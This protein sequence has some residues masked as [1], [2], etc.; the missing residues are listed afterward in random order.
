MSLPSRKPD[1]S[2][3]NTTHTLQILV[4]IITH[5]NCFYIALFCYLK[6]SG[7]G[8]RFPQGTIVFWEI[9]ATHLKV[10]LESSYFSIRATNLSYLVRLGREGF[11]S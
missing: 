9:L 7:Y 10:M 3:P 11:S 5:L 1:P 6:A 8:G 2:W 4:L